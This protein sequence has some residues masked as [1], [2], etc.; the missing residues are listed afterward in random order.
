LY[1]N[2][3]EDLSIEL[4]KHLIQ[5]RREGLIT[6]WQKRRIIAG[7]EWERQISEHLESALLIILLISPDF[8]EIIPKRGQ[9]SRLVER[10]FFDRCKQHV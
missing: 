6:T 1:A 2:A 4:E 10:A 9:T 3:D 5:L 8:L 7:T